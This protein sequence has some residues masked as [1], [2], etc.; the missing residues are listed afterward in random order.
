MPLMFCSNPETFHDVLTIMFKR[1]PGQE[2]VSR[3]QYELLDISEHSIMEES[4]W[5]EKVKPGSTVKMSVMLPLASARRAQ[6]RSCPRCGKNNNLHEN[7]QRMVKCFFCHLYYEVIE[8]ERIVE[9]VEPTKPRVRSGSDDNTWK[10]GQ[11][12]RPTNTRRTSSGE[13]VQRKFSRP[14]DPFKRISYVNEKISLQH[15]MSRDP[16]IKLRNPFK[17]TGSSTDLL[18]DIVEMGDA[19]AVVGIAEMGDIDAVRKWLQDG[20]SPDV[21]DDEGKPLLHAA[22]R[23]GN[24][25]LVRLLI[26]HDADV[27]IQ[28]GYWHSALQAAAGMAQAS[29]API[30]KLLLENNADPHALG[31]HYGDALQAAAAFCGQHGNDEAVQLLLEYGAEVNVKGGTYGS[32]LQALAFKGEAEMIELLLQHDVDVNV[33]SGPWDTALQA[34][35]ATAYVGG[36]EAVRVLLENGADVNARG[37]HF[38]TALHAA[39]NTNKEGIVKLLLE[40]GADINARG[41]DGA[42]AL[43]QAADEGNAGVVRVLLAAGADLDIKNKWDFTA[44]EV[45]AKH[46]RHD[47]VQLLQT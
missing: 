35:A 11:V 45:A 32:P 19:D 15:K 1:L 6:T 30:V 46:G 7:D 22:A 29:S 26:Q 13:K 38:E 12:K 36:E 14:E 39:A 2:Q 25:S 18:V 42:T 47:V 31:G 21:T 44:A 41:E 40:N 4:V 28:G 9:V 16:S 27:N 3:R 20:G 24:E 43:H 10:A 17:G 5:H 34:A 23:S 33:R 37:G 8:K